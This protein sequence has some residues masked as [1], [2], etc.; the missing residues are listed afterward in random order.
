MSPRLALLLTTSGLAAGGCA[1]AD[2]APGA[3]DVTVVDSAMSGCEDLG[4]VEGKSGGPGGIYMSDEKLL[5]LAVDDM[6]DQAA[7][8]GATHVHARKSRL[9]RL[10][11][12]TN[13]GFATGVAYRCGGGATSTKDAVARRIR[14]AL[15]QRSADILAC[16]AEDRLAVR[17]HHAPDAT[18]T[19]SL[20]GDLED[21]PEQDC[22]AALLEDLTIDT[23]GTEGTV[24][25]VVR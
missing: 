10:N 25:H 22:V 4:T 9:G 14:A 24:V 20:Q 11:G 15:D 23:E 21:T 17:I 2:A 16:V 1:R 18:L 6:L 7:R 19:V 5:K 12:V 8:L 13:R 3:E